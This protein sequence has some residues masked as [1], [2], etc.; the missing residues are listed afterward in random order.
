MSASQ[1]N[2][3]PVPFSNMVDNN[4]TLTA[5]Q[6]IEWTLT[7]S[8]LVWQQALCCMSSQEIAQ[9]KQQ[10]ELSYYKM[11]LYS[12]HTVINIFPYCSHLE[13]FTL[14]RQSVSQSTPVT[15]SAYI[16][17]SIMP[18]KTWYIHYHKDRPPIRQIQYLLLAL[19]TYSPE[20]WLWRYDISITTK[21]KSDTD[22][23]RDECLMGW[24]LWNHSTLRF[25]SP[26]GI[27]VHSKWAESP[28]FRPSKLCKQKNKKWFT[29]RTKTQQLS[30][31]FWGT[32]CLSL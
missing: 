1:R 29:L 25:G 32:V 28:S 26:T 8:D 6:Q 23:I 24:P 27:S 9:V 4:L 19:H 17:S 22:F 15:G 18:V 21:P 16:F 13:F 11:S 14:K 20:S 5:I 2:I 12:R 31:L 7:P 30:C 3:L 10:C